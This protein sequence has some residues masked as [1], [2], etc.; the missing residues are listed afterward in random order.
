MIGPK[1]FYFLFYR[2]FSQQVRVGG[3][4]KN[5]NKIHS[6]HFPIKLKSKETQL[7]YL[8]NTSAVTGGNLI[9]LAAIEKTKRKNITELPE[10]EGNKEIKLKKISF[11]FFQFPKYWVGRVCKMKNKKT[12]ALPTSSFESSSL[13]EA[14]TCSSSF[15]P[16]F[17][18]TACFVVQNV[19]F[20]L[21]SVEVSCRSTHLSYP[22]P[23]YP[24]ILIIYN[25]SCEK[26]SLQGFR[27]GMT[28]SQTRLLF[29]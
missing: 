9:N 22:A 21:C 18:M 27:P 5:K 24:C 25:W 19:S 1:F 29:V 11:F 7:Q 23:E 28:Q 10:L 14:T 12:L 16:S 15:F 2:F 6:D 3:R 4:N 17:L 13:S 20:I 8:T 26:T